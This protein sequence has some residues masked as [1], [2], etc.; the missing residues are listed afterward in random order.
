MSKKLFFLILFFL[1]SIFIFSDKVP[2]PTDYPTI[3]PSARIR[4]LGGNGTS[5]M[6]DI[7]STFYN[8][9][10]LS[11]LNSGGISISFETDHFSSYAEFIEK[12]QS[13]Y[14]KNISFF[15]ISTYQG[16]LSYMPLFKISYSDSFFDSLNIERDFEMKLNQYWLSLTSFTGFNEKFTS[17]IYFGINLKYLN[18]K[19]AETKL[20]YDSS[21][22]VIDG[23][24]D[25]SY[26]NGYG[27]DGGL[28]LSL[29]NLFISLVFRDIFTHIYWDFYDKQ[30]IP[31]N[32]NLGS[33]FVPISNLLFNFN[34]S[35]FLK[36]EAP[37]VYTV[38]FEYTFFEL[39]EK[40]NSFWDDFKKGS[41][42]IRV[43][44]S[45]KEIPTL[46]TAIIDLGLGYNSNSMRFDFCLES[47]LERY[48]V[49][50]FDYY[51]TLTI[52]ITI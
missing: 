29:S 31:M 30:I 34:I 26:G 9:A 3:F 35:K 44:T 41:P 47:T 49:G 13:I 36:R 37:F 7:S 4:G 39:S 5:V 12:E 27:F 1:A 11:G 32:G 40:T 50:K 24:A 21:G 16:G 18:G 38:G 46:S 43:G 25:I 48:Y 51:L 22:N 6:G 33:S 28:V 17:P 52:P 19:I 2:T 14:G 23:F 42:S 15:T 45:F 10:T 20:F 8:P